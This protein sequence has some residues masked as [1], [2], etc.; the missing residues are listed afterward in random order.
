MRGS[1]MA[2]AMALA[3]AACSNGQAPVG[4]SAGPAPSDLLAVYEGSEDGPLGL[5]QVEV[6]IQ[7][8]PA[9]SGTI[10]TGQALVQLTV[11]GRRVPTSLPGRFR[12]DGVETELRGLP[13]GDLIEVYAGLGGEQDWITAFR[14][15]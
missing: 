15:R 1:T 7:G 8:E 3:M 4:P 9:A 11:D 14:T 6:R 12:I 13:E 10:F 5:V 2:I